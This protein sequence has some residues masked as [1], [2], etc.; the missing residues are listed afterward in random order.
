MEELSVDD[1]SHRNSIW[2][3]P[4]WILTFVISLLV[5][6]AY[7]GLLQRTLKCVA[8]DRRTIS[9]WTVWVMLIPFVNLIFQFFLVAGIADSLRSEFNFRKS[10]NREDRPGYDLGLLLCLATLFAPFCI[11]EKSLGLVEVIF[12]IAY[13]VKIS[14]F[15]KQLGGQR[16]EFDD[17][18]NKNKIISQNESGQSD[19]EIFRDKLE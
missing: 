2:D 14:G 11:Y 5:Y 13:W 6:I 10:N 16:I 8:K 4:W 3:H 1:Y 12:W 19:L 7:L 17:W 9:A 15:R 18:E